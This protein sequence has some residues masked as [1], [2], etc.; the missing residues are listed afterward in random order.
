MDNPEWLVP[1]IT[2]KSPTAAALGRY[3]EYP[4][5]MYTGLPTIEIPI[6]EF[7]VGNLTVPIKLT[8]HA[9]GNRVADRASWVGLGWSLQTGGMISRTVQSRPDEQDSGGNGSLGR[10]I[11]QPN[12]DTGCPTITS[13]QALGRLADN[14]RDSQRDLFTYRVPGGSNT[15]TLTP[16]GES[17][18]VFLRAEPAQLTYTGN[19]A[20]FLLTDPTGTRYRFADSETTF[21]SAGSPNGF[22]NYG[23]TWHLNEITALNTSERISMGYARAGL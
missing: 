5:S 21:V 7:R 3:G 2:P 15:F 20:E 19:L 11:T 16:N 18:T 4:V 10:S 9:A 6:H 12:Y 13:T 23:S 8:Y 1:S 17:G 14:Q 22:T